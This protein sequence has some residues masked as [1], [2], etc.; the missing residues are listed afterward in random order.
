LSAAERGQDIARALFYA[1]ARVPTEARARLGKEDHQDHQEGSSEKKDHQEGFRGTRALVYYTRTAMSMQTFDVVFSDK[2]LTWQGLGDDAA[3]AGWGAS[4]APAGCS[5]GPAAWGAS[6]AP[7]GCSGGP[8]AW[9]A[10]DAEKAGAHGAGAGAY[11]A[12]WGPSGASAGAGPAG[13]LLE[14]ARCGR[15]EGSKESSSCAAVPRGAPGL[16]AECQ[17]CTLLALAALVGLHLAMLR[18]LTSLVVSVYI[19]VLAP[20]LSAFY[21]VSAAAQV[22]LYVLNLCALTVLLVN[23]RYK[24]DLSALFFGAG[25]LALLHV[26]WKDVTA[27]AGSSFTAAEAPARLDARARALVCVCAGANVLAAYVFLGRADAD[28]YNPQLHGAQALLLVLDALVYVGARR[29]A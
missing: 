24:R 18:S 19:L 16:S 5:G 17:A 13:A 8:A 25:A 15:L 27:P 7:A 22:H 28:E 26:L 21:Q 10:R 14:R 9:R 6:G 1:E 4:G 2:T 29:R 11:G 3:R 23:V 20:L 12:G